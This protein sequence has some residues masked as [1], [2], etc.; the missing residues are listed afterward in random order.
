MTHGTGKKW[1][2]LITDF[3]YGKEKICE[4]VKAGIDYIQLREKNISSAEYLRR[5]RLLMEW[6]ENSGARL[7]LMTEWILLCSVGQ[8]ACI[9]GRRIFR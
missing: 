8:T 4:A 9:W 5:A 2:Y 7:S 1:L 3:S 6:A